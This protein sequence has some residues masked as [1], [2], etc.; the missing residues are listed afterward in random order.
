MYSNS[1]TFNLCWVSPERATI[2]QHAQRY[3]EGD[4]APCCGVAW[5]ITLLP[6]W[7]RRYSRVI[8][9]ACRLVFDSQTTNIMQQIDA[10]LSQF[11]HGRSLY[12][13]VR[14]I[15][16]LVF[17]VSLTS[18]LYIRT[19]GSYHIFK[20]S[21]REEIFNFF[22]RGEFIIPFSLFVIVYYITQWIPA[23]VLSAITFWLRARLARVF[24][25]KKMPKRERNSLINSFVKY[26]RYTPTPLTKAQAHEIMG[27]FITHV[28]Q[29]ELQL[30]IKETEAPIK[31]LEA[32][33]ILFFIDPALMIRTYAA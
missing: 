25:H 22:T 6:V 16:N 10:L 31:T 29:D 11:L 30:M 14:R 8:K 27:L 24:T 9:L 28:T 32:N 5:K 12:A 19:H 17:A 1:K 20:L 21:Q 2:G 4:P 7:N 26:S 18:Y 3:P 13:P 33:L 15:L 23:V